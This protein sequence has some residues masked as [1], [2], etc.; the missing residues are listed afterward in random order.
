MG[1]KLL[2]KRINVLIYYESSGLC[3]GNLELWIFVGE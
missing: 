3:W 2:I 1:G